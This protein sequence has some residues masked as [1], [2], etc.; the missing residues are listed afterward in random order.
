LPHTGSPEPG[1]G[2]LPVLSGLAAQLAPLEHSADRIIGHHRDQFRLL[3]HLIGGRQQRF[4]NGEAEDVGGLEVDDQ[5]DFCD[6][7]YREVGWLSVRQWRPSLAR[8]T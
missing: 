3:D 2:G 5:I 4:G 1:L 8:T 7:L 6:P